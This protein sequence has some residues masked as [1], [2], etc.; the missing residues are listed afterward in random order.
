MKV[1]TLVLASAI[2]LVGTPDVDR[3]GCMVHDHQPLQVRRMPIT[4][5]TTSKPRNPL[6]DEADHCDATMREGPP[7][8]KVSSTEV[9]P[10]GLSC[11]PVT[12]VPKPSLVDREANLTG[13]YYFHDRPLASGPDTIQVILMV[14]REQ[15][16]QQVV[17]VGRALD[18]GAHAVARETLR[19]EGVRL[20]GNP[21]P[22]PF[23][24]SLE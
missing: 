19:R 15:G 23:P 11:G 21:R 17:W 3:H 5:A 16:L 13:L 18:R 22:G 7:G 1:A 24:D 2:S 10:F 4:P 6:E 12:G 14:C 8:L 9:A 20:H